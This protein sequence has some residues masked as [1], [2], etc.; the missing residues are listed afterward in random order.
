MFA[1]LQGLCIYDG[2]PSGVTLSDA[3]EGSGLGPWLLDKFSRLE[4][5]DGVEERWDEGC[6]VPETS[7]YRRCR[8][9]LALRA[10]QLGWS[11][12]SPD[13][14]ALG[15]LALRDPLRPYRSI[16][17]PRHSPFF[18]TAPAATSSSAALAAGALPHLQG[19]PSVRLG[20]LLPDP[21][22][23]AELPRH[24]GLKG[25]QREVLVQQHREAA[26]R[27]QPVAIAAATAPP[28]PLAPPQP[29]PPPPPPLPAGSRPSGHAPVFLHQ[30]ASTAWDFGVDASFLLRHIPARVILH[31]P[32]LTSTLFAQ[33]TALKAL[34]LEEE[35]SFTASFAAEAAAAAASAA[36]LP[37]HPA[38]ASTTPAAAAATASEL[39]PASVGAS[40]ESGAGAAAPAQNPSPDALKR[41]VAQLG[42]G[43][44]YLPSGQ[45][46][47][48]I[49]GA[50]G[51]AGSQKSA[52]HSQPHTPQYLFRPVNLKGPMLSLAYLMASPIGSV[53]PAPKRPP[54]PQGGH[55]RAWRAA[56]RA[57][58]S[59][60]VSTI[61]SCSRSASRPSSA[62][63]VCSA[64][65][66]PQLPPRWSLLRV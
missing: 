51:G 16:M 30:Y 41:H 12:S 27:H 2:S 63:R 56:P 40:G 7:L 18:S 47:S 52:P 62:P 59:L 50:G 23:P 53:E 19:F 43:N 38:P 28:L 49:G 24:R 25:V 58:A 35:A 21:A 54:P 45:H 44:L 13:D 39:L 57:S 6:P 36:Q 8:E 1:Q 64:A 29:L 61:C 9:L 55:F 5:G 20:S 34:A 4:R 3:E 26:R 66:P 17:M 15:S 48:R 46:H 65:R 10:E 60:G 32:W 31:V 11:G 37:A 42:R 22:A 33:W 14:A